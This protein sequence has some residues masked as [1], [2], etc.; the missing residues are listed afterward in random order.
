M[1]TPWIFNLLYV[2]IVNFYHK[3]LTDR[4]SSEKPLHKDFKTKA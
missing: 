4:K 1:Q 2:F 3:I